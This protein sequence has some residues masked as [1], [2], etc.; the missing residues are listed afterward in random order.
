M[1]A[2]FGWDCLPVLDKT[3]DAY[4][5]EF[6]SPTNK[7]NTLA[8]SSYNRRSQMYQVDTRWSGRVYGG[9]S[10][11]G[12]GRGGCGGRNGRGCGH[13]CGDRYTRNNPYMIVRGQN[14]SF[15]P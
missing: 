2:K 9:R 6:L 8:S 14:G 10:G 7:Q 4:Y 3:L 12:C 5:N 11:R 15:L 13:G 1:N